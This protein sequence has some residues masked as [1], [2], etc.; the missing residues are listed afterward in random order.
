MA[1]RKKKVRH[2][3][4]IDE[5][6]LIPYADLLTLLLALFIVLFAMSSVDATKFQ[7]L[8]KSFNEIF[9]GGTGLMDFT[10]P[11]DGDPTKGNR[12][13]GALMDQDK[14]TGSLGK[15]DTEELSELQQRVTDFI[16]ENGLDD[17]LETSLTGEGLLVSIRDHVLFESGSADVRMEDIHIA[18]EIASLMVMDPPRSIVIS[19]YT[20]NVPISTA[21][22]G[23]NWD[24]SVMRAVNF[25]KVLL[26]NPKLNPEWFSAKGYGEFKPVA[27]N[28]TAEGRAKNR[29]VEILI[30]PRTVLGE[31]G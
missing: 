12:D 20:D 31:E 25:M 30:S 15:K 29:R 9:S 19:G 26:E 11:T 4:H 7:Q 5:S 28:G 23:S 6:W 22:Y 18:K 3:E 10:A 2:D 8:S 14:G 16:E 17:K 24:L 21:R 1:R 13:E 27:S